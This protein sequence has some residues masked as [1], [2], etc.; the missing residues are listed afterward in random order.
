MHTAQQHRGKGVARIMVEN[1]LA[2]AK[3]AATGGSAW[4]PAQWMLA[5]ARKLYSRFGFVECPPFG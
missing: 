5:P 4:R 3:S 2:E 1:I